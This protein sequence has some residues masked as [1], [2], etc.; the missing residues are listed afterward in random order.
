M[1]KGWCN[2][3]DSSGLVVALVAIVLAIFLLVLSGREACRSVGHGGRQI[4]DFQEPQ[5]CCADSAPRDGASR[6]DLNAHRDL[7]ADVIRR[8]EARVRFPQAARA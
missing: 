4:V 5:G 1:T 8:S 3:I 6:C 7:N 2:V